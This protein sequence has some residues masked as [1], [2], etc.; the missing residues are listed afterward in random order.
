MI[1]DEEFI[2]YLNDNGK[3]RS[4]KIIKLCYAGKYKNAAEDIID[5]Y[6]TEMRSVKNSMFLSPS[7]GNL[8]S[9]L[10]T[11]LSRCQI[12]R[13]IA[14]MLL[15]VVEGLN[16]AN[17]SGY[18]MINHSISNKSLIKSRNFTKSNHRLVGNDLPELFSFLPVI[19]QSLLSLECKPPASYFTVTLKYDMIETVKM[20]FIGKK[21]DLLKL[22]LSDVRS[23]FK[24]HIQFQYIFCMKT[25]KRGMSNDGYIELITDDML[26]WQKNE[27]DWADSDSIDH[28]ENKT[29]Y[30]SR[31]FPGIDNHDEYLK[32][33]NVKEMVTIIFDKEERH[34]SRRYCSKQ[35]YSSM[36]IST[37]KAF[38]IRPM[39]DCFSRVLVKISD[40]EPDDTLM[41][42]IK[43]LK[44]EYKPSFKFVNLKDVFKQN[45]LDL[46]DLPLKDPEPEKLFSND[47]DIIENF[48]DM[49]RWGSLSLLRPR[50][51][52]IRMKYSEVYRHTGRELQL[53]KLLLHSS[54]NER[55]SLAK[56]SL[57]YRLTAS[58]EHRPQ[59]IDHS[60]TVA[61]LG[62]SPF[63]E[64][65]FDADNYAGINERR[66]ELYFE[67]A[68]DINND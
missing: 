49:Y 16:L 5:G 62:L 40:K 19:S 38:G 33:I 65:H 67:L 32:D 42:Q 58:I 61:G 54:K 2:R 28:G 52:V 57:N 41:D 43:S 35:Q 30:L 56:D 8:N 17:A 59:S 44:Y 68:N 66:R 23:K 9:N 4:V 29:Y 47:D 51:I 13:I 11:D 63:N 39:L 14:S 22:T 37:F 12:Q 18:D 27:G 60:M 64:T 1:D 48:T 7:L 21:C 15:H 26:V 34:I 25:S 31:L 20:Y 6:S 10:Y 55:L 3:I 53:D 45:N 46:I 36:Y 24:K 50:I